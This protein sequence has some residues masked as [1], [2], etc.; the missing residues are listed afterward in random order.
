MNKKIAEYKVRPLSFDAALAKKVTTRRKKGDPLAAIAK[1]LK[2]GAGKAA[3]AELVGT[4][5]RVNIEDP[6][7]LARAVVKDRRGGDSWGL[8]AARYG[9]TEGTA[10]AAYEAAAGEPFSNLDFRK[11]V[12]AA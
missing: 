5:E 3:M 1:D 12:E 10:R 4:T 2:V 6:A 8:L 11:K 9:I 7:Q